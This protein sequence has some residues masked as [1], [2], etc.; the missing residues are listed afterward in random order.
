MPE[1][2]DIAGNTPIKCHFACRKELSIEVFEEKE[3]C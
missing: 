2:L 3:P 1:D